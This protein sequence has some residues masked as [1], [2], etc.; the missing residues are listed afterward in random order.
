MNKKGD[1][2]LTCKIAWMAAFWLW[3][4]FFPVAMS[5]LEIDGWPMMAWYVFISLMLLGTT[6][7]SDRS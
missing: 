2:G 6:V 4:F 1:V 3:T 5:L 7:Q